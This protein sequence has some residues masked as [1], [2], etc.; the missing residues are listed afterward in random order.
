MRNKVYPE[1]KMFVLRVCRRWKV[2]FASTIVA[3]V[4]EESVVADVLADGPGQPG[5]RA[6]AVEVEIRKGVQMDYTFL[7]DD[8]ACTAAALRGTTGFNGVRFAMA[9]LDTWR[10][11]L[12]AMQSP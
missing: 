7:S 4:G 2:S 3:P 1:R 8:G 5:G 6:A 10:R 11:R 12:K 9:F